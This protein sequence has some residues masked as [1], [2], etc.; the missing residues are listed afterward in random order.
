VLYGLE[1]KY[2]A[3][4]RLETKA[5]A[6]FRMVLG[7]ENPVT[8]LSTNN[9][10][11]LYQEEGKYRQAEAL[12]KKVLEVR[13]REP[14]PQHPDTIDAMASL[15]ETQLQQQSYSTAEPLLRE[16]L[17]NWDKIGS[18]GWKR[19]Y[20]QSLLGASLAGQERYMEAEPLL[21]SGYQGMSQRAASIPMESRRVLPQ[22]GERIV[23]LYKQWEKPE[24]AA[25]WRDRLQPK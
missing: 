21:V 7:E 8:L 12:W 10:A 22:A 5:Q 3:G 16:A 15:G 9:L 2:A 25:E 20:G 14:G 17:S 13:R 18:D 19:Y 4:E 6:T 1:G 23:Q 11:A 24:K